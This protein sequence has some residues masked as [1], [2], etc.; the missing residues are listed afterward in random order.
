MTNQDD[1]RRIALS[2]PETT[3]QPNRFEFRVRNKTF[4]AVYPER[5]HP[6]KAR[7][8]NPDGL[9]VRVANLDEKDALLSTSHEA[10]FTT[11]HYDG[12]AS[13]IVWLSKLELDE[14]ED[15]IVDAWYAMAPPDLTAAFDAERDSV[16]VRESDE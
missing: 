1:V 15:L 13:V 6:K 9:V 16:V 10:F 8:P 7:V 5:I 4:V 3:E 14:L 2:L 12:Y 11:D